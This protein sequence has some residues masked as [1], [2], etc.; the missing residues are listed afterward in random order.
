MIF[1]FLKDGE[2]AE[3]SPL[4]SKI[5]RKSRSVSKLHKYRERRLNTLALAIQLNCDSLEKQQAKR[6]QRQFKTGNIKFS[7]PNSFNSLFVLFTENMQWTQT[8]PYDLNYNLHMNYIRNMSY[9]KEI[10]SAVLGYVST[11]K[12]K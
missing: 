6:N 2:Q 8:F 5:R 3:S 7:F 4:T 12:I 1:F 9:T 10:I 11:N